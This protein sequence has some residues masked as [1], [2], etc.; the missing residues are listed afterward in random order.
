MQNTAKQPILDKIIDISVDKEKSNFSP[1]E[2]ANILLS[3]LSQ[4]EADI[5][6]MRYGFTGEKPKTLESI[7]K[8][9][10]LTRER[11]RQIEKQALKNITKHKDY[12]DSVAS[13][14]HMLESLVREFGGLASEEKI[15]KQLANLVK[16]KDEARAVVKFLLN[17]FVDSIEGFKADGF[18]SS[19]RIY[20]LSIDFV[21]T[22]LDELKKILV[23]KNKIL[24]ESELIKF[25]KQSNYFKNDFKIPNF[26]SEQELD[27]MILSYLDASSKFANSPFDQ[28]GLADWGVINPRRI[29]GKIYLVMH[30]HK[31]PLHFSEIADLIN[32]AWKDARDIKTATVHNELIFD[33]RFVLVGRGKYG[34]KEWGYEGGNVTDAIEN[35][36][37]KSGILLSIEEIIEKIKVKKMVKEGTIKLALKNKDKFK[38]E[39][40][41]YCL[42]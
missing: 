30:K 9:M 1:S 7:G 34:L 31:K 39:N 36:L 6:K 16:N 37:K 3:F 40:G 22:I 15:F 29:N 2:V 20:D 28:W 17:N 11:V 21:N 12:E 38:L 25:F 10:N 23:A 13:F 33:P 24:Y 26:L 32:N 5:I 4:R 19:L 8:K 35:L 42:V 41:K 14:K 18:K 27:K